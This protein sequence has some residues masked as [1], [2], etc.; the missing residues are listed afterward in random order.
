MSEPPQPPRLMSDAM[1]ANIDIRHTQTAPTRA[2]RVTMMQPAEMMTPPSDHVTSQNDAIVEVSPAL[3]FSRAIMLN[4]SET[5][6]KTFIRDE[7]QDAEAAMP[8]LQR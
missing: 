2:R 8:M 3:L 1:S 7:A 4:T 6:C 5:F